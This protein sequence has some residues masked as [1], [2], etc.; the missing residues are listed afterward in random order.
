MCNI[1]HTVR[2]AQ[3]RR[4][5]PLLLQGEH[6]GVKTEG[7][8]GVNVTRAEGHGEAPLDLKKSTPN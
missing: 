5:C 4:G 3:V 6:S 1:F 8:I 7:S 2:E